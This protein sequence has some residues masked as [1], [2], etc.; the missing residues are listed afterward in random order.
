MV[1]TSIK[2][3]PVK[4][5][6]TLNTILDTYITSIT[7][8][9]IV[10][11]TSKIVSICEGSVVKNDG[12]VKKSDLMKKY[13]QRY[14]EPGS[15]KYDISLSV[16]GNIL[17][18]ASGIDESNGNGYYILWPR[19]AYETAADVWTYLRKT[20]NVTHLGV[21]ITDS[22]VTPLRWG[23]RGI[24]IGWCGFE[25]LRDYREQ[26]DIFG[27]KLRMT[28]LSVLDGLA[29]SAV[30]VMGEGNEQTP[31]V[32]IHDAPHIVYTDHPPA[33]EDITELRIEPEDDLFAPIINFEKMKKGEGK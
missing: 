24:G 13:A 5:G 33:K 6:D 14:L 29:A 22:I 18:A 21:V 12:S 31:L 32:L 19:D 4:P 9:D 25:P 16:T 10:V 26:P 28:K 3:R 1:I 8:G 15:S 11:I 20:R 17:V 2:T 7:D 27:R 23:T 30:L